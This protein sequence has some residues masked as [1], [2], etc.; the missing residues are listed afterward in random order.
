MKTLEGK[1]AIITGGTSGIGAACAERLAQDG[2]AVLIAGRDAA[3]GEDIARQICHS[4]GQADFHLLDI[5]DDK[6]I[7]AFAQNV[8]RQYEHAD[9]LFNNAGI[10]PKFP[11]LDDIE[12]QG[13][14][15]VFDVN[16]I[17]MMMVTKFFL[18]LLRKNC[19]VI[20]NNASVA[21][22]Q[23][24]ASGQGYAYAASKSA[25]IQFSRM[26]AKIY[27]DKIRVNCICPGVID[28]PLYFNLDREK[29]S[30]RIPAGRIGSPKDV[31]NLVAFLASDSANYIYGA[32]IPIDGGLTL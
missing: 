31:A 15:Q 8:R 32:V 17:G 16:I 13:A 6:S 25:V 29:F 28:T 23:S 10:Y 12:R 11:P 7:A 18:P 3:R 24:F 20:I 19:G 1:I 14:E 30:Q 5:S 4:G 26:L 2:A 27:A 22:L 9:I 21:G